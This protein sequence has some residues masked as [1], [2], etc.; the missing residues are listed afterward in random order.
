MQMGNSVMHQ[1]VLR[2]P[3]APVAGASVH[4]EALSCCVST[5]Q[6]LACDCRQ[7]AQ[8]NDLQT[9]SEPTLCADGKTIGNLEDM[10][11][12]AAALHAFGPQYVLVKVRWLKSS[13]LWVLCIS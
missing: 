3:V 8:E 12:A 7:D 10:K 2:F 1:R 5:L 4:R 9:S 13:G 11:E 6:T